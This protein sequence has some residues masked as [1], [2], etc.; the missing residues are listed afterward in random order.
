MWQLRNSPFL[1]VVKSMSTV[2]CIHVGL[3]VALIFSSGNA[4]LRQTMAISYTI[5]I[6]LSSEPSQQTIQTFLAS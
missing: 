4:V 3:R 1:R 5:T 2:L 6:L